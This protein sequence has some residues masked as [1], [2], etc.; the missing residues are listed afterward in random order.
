[1][2]KILF[3]AFGFSL[4]LCFYGCGSAWEGGSGSGISYP[5]YAN[6]ERTA[7]ISNGVG[8][9]VIGMPRNEVVKIMGE[10][11]EVTQLYQTL[12]A[13]Q[14]GQSSGYSYIYL[15]QRKKELGSIIERQEKLYKLSFNLNDGLIKIES[16]G[17]HIR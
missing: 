1:M 4:S 16:E 9:L 2:L 11:D 7:Q 14:K 13:I 12:D 6:A 3:M 10:P 17:T 5:Y 15:I 8:R